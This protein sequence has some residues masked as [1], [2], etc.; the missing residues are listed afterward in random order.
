MADGDTQFVG[1][2]PELYDSYLVPLIF[3]SYADDLAIRIAELSPKSVL[4]I[5]AGSGVVSRSVAIAY[6]QG[7]PLRN[8]I[9]SLDAS[10]LS[11]AT[12]RATEEIALRFGSENVSAKTQGLVVKATR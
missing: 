12:D 4:E 7:T 2:I 1:S 8:E 3:E 9:E 10:L 5:A 11:H 6:C